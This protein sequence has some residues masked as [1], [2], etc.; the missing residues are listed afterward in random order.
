MIVFKSMQGAR[1]TWCLYKDEMYRNVDTSEKS[2]VSECRHICP[3]SDT[4]KGVQLST[5][6][7]VSPLYCRQGICVLGKNIVLQNHKDLILNKISK[8][9]LDN[10]ENTF[11]YDD[12]KILTFSVLDTEKYYQD[13]QIVNQ[14]CVN[15][16][17]S[18]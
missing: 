4:S 11:F 5:E 17:F 6:S 14:Q 7:L 1:K 3:H 10:L 15:L 18:K 2:D 12:S 13:D 9:I 16:H 8:K